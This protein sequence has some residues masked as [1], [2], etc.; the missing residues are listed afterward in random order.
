MDNSKFI[1]KVCFT[2][3]KKS[4]NLS[5]VTGIQ[6]LLEHA[7]TDFNTNN[8]Y[9]KEI[10][11]AEINPADGVL[12]VT[13]TSPGKLNQPSKSLNLFSRY[14]AEYKAFSGM[15]YG[16]HL[17]QC[18]GCET[19]SEPELIQEEFSLTRA[20]RERMIGIC[21]RAFYGSSPEDIQLAKKLYDVIRESL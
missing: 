1:Y 15:T 10:I 16:N 11:K 6:S 2:L 19:I 21:A 4:K 5:K 8:T 17:F 7:K 18:C 3:A 13:F 9:G 20:E 12:E 14:L